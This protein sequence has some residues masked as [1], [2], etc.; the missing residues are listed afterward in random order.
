STIIHLVQRFYD[1][2][3]GQVL[4]DNNDIRHLN[5]TWL[6]SNMSVVSQEPVL[7]NDTIAEN[8]RFGH[9]TASDEEIK[10]AAQIAN[11]HNF[12]IKE[13]PN[14][15]NTLVQG[16]HLAGGQKQRIA[17]ARAVL[18]NPKILLLDEATSALDAKNESEVQIGLERASQGRTTI[19][20]AHR[21]TTIRKAHHIIGLNAGQIDEQGT[22]EELMRLNG[23]YAQA[24]KLQR[25][26]DPHDEN[27]ED[28]DNDCEN[29]N[30][31]A[32]GNFQRHNSRR[33]IRSETSSVIS[34]NSTKQVMVRTLKNICRKPFFLRI[35]ALNSPEWFSILLGSIT[36][37]IYGAV[38][39]A[40]AL[41]L[42]LV[43]GLFSQDAETAERNARNYSIIVFFVGLAGGLCQFISSYAFTRSGEALTVRM[44]VMSF[45]TLLRQEMSWYDE[46]ENQQNIL[47]TRLSKDAAALKGMTGVTIGAFLN[48]VGTLVAGLAISFVAGWKLTLVLLCFTPLIVITGYML[49]QK[50]S[51]AGQKK[52]FSTHAELGSMYATESLKNIRTVT[53]LGLQDH[54]IRLYKQ[55]Y[56]K[57]FR[58]SLWQS[59][60][61]VVGNALANTLMFF[62]QLAAFGYG[63][64]LV[65]DREM[66]Y[67]GVFQVFAV[68]TYATIA[69]GRSASMVPNYSRAKEAS[70]RI[71]NLNARQSRIDPDN[72]NEGEI[73]E[74]VRG[75]LE[76]RDVS[77]KYPSRKESRVLRHLSFTCNKGE[78]TGI[79]GPSGSGKSTCIALLERFYDPQRGKV[80]LDGHDLR[81]IN[82]KWLRSIIGL[83]QQEPVLFNISIRDNIAYGDTTREFTD[84]EIYE[85]ARQADIHDT[86]IGL[87]EGYDTMCGSSSQVQLA[88]GQKQRIAIA[89]LLIRNPKIVLFDE[90]TSALNAAVEER[91]MRT[92]NRTRA[93]RTCVMVAHRLSTI[94]DCE[95]IVVLVRGRVD[96][97]G[98]DEQL[99][100]NPHGTYSQ[101]LRAAG[102]YTTTR[103]TDDI[104]TESF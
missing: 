82:V 11:I 72:E 47:V 51:K 96:E 76:F 93:D 69:F 45:A 77:L 60:R 44:R 38:T 79:V 58:L 52:A 41:I 88:G 50:L 2:E 65:I 64:R 89:R 78:A 35:L 3:E 20:V 40:Y 18:S 37:L 42:A 85:A 9:E 97:E 99:A 46:E 83:V 24:V 12:I 28:E 27:D 33:S 70:I 100:T 57:E 66:T 54:F 19:V 74:R 63:A 104:E 86:I 94:R 7:F 67:I 43:F 103:N 56:N 15:Y 95:K 55:A 6:R 81:T 68:I 26:M 61:I 53:S 36:S 62:I 101:L 14:G 75:V 32:S 10:A 31:H 92:F 84:A 48:A 34:N 4:L 71:M 90:A 59:Q 22:H 25:I 98:T 16:S 5:V 91:I 17:I 21:L 30:N 87:A 23:R 39:P 13:L 49:G 102:L 1:P 80:L 73:L 8:I 29:G